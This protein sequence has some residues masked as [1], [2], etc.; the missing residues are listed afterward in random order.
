MTVDRALMLRQNERCVESTSSGE[1]RLENLGAIFSIVSIFFTHPFFWAL[2]VLCTFY[3]MFMYGSSHVLW[4]IRC[5]LLV[6]SF[7]FVGFLFTPNTAKYVDSHDNVIGKWSPAAIPMFIGTLCTTAEA[8]ISGF[9]PRGGPETVLTLGF[10]FLA[11][12]ITIY[13]RRS[14]ISH[15]PDSKCEVTDLYWLDYGFSWPGPPG[16]L[17]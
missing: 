17:K 8:F 2:L 3:G 12:P 1:R 6:A 14:A 5:I 13:A 9:L 10:A 4:E 11:V 7:W 15:E 16:F